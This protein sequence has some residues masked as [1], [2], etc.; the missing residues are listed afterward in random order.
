MSVRLANPEKDDTHS[1]TLF[2]VTG[3]Q[4]PT[5][6]AVAHNLVE[7]EIVSCV[8]C[9]IDLVRGV[10]CGVGSTVLSGV[11]MSKSALKCVDD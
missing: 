10:D 2:A 8:L 3:G 11:A 5:F 7:R 1:T 4:P 9:R 6:L